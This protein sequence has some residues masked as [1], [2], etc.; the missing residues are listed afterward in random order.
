M[1]KRRTRKQRG[2]AWPFAA[3]KPLSSVPQANFNTSKNVTLEEAQKWL[4][5]EE[6]KLEGALNNATTV[7]AAA[8]GVVDAISPEPSDQTAEH[9]AQLKDTA[10]QLQEGLPPEF[11]PF[12][13]AYDILSKVKE[14]NPNPTFQEFKE[15]VRRFLGQTG[16]GLLNPKG[17]WFQ[18]KEG[19][20]GKWIAPLG[21]ANSVSSGNMFVEFWFS[22]LWIFWTLFITLPQWS[23][24]FAG[25]TLPK[26]ILKLAYYTMGKYYSNNPSKLTEVIKEQ[27]PQATATEAVQTTGNPLLAAKVLAAK[28]PLLPTG[29]L[30]AAPNL[31]TTPKAFTTA[32]KSPFTAPAKNRPRDPSGYTL[33]QFG[34]GMVVF[35]RDGKQLGPYRKDEIEESWSQRDGLWYPK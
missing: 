13:Q 4:E 11:P 31:W 3:K 17:T 20:K 16:G 25:W 15:L 34:T 21:I 2:G 28:A 33:F 6:A 23:A 32:A 14:Q 26:N 29:S 24:R 35:Q 9:G 27:S 19:R 5:K 18:G 10:E 12:E 22:V 8:K 30:T 7:G 1:R